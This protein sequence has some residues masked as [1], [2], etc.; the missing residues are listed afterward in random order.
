M[1]SDDELDAA[2]DAQIEQERSE[3]AKEPK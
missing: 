2:I 1:L 3:Q